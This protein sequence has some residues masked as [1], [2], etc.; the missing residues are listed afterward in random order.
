[1]SNPSRAK[2]GA[3][4]LQPKSAEEPVAHLREA[5]GHASSF[6]AMVAESLATAA[7]Q[8]ATM[9]QRLTEL[10]RR[11]G[12]ME[13]DSHDLALRLVASEQQSARLMSLY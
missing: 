3:S 11:L 7:S 10:E 1:M 4:P 13:E 9:E 2:C 6:V 8:V 5:L 12:E